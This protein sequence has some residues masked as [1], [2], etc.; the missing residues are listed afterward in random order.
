LS[1]TTFEYTGLKLD[2]EA[3][4][5]DET[6]TVN[7]TVKNTGGRD[8]L[9]NV[10]LFISD[11]YASLSPA[12]RKLRDFEKVFIAAGE[13]QTVTFELTARDLSFVNLALERVVE[14]GEFK[15]TAGDLSQTFVYE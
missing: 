9:H 1:Y 15:I 7:V 6:L 12:A 2:R 3:M 8:G 10:D 4:R 13:S 11:L 5:E 14:P